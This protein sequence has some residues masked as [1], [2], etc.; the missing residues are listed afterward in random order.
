VADPILNHWP[1]TSEHLPPQ[2]LIRLLN[3][4]MP[5]GDIV[6]TVD[7]GGSAI[8]ATDKLVYL[9]CPKYK[10]IIT[11]WMI[12]GDAAGAAVFDIW[13]SAY[14]TI[15][16]VANTITAAA[17]P[18]IIVGDAG[19]ARSTDVST[20]TDVEVDEDDILAFNLDSCTI[21]EKLS[22]AISIARGDLK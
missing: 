3:R 4:Y 6:V 16:T 5:A 22:L 13:K 10:F 18:T 21:F 14:P 1:K 12:I 8:S 15:P 9:P 20:W 11:G 7:G 17:K 19:A 2:T